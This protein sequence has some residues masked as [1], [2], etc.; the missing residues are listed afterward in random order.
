[1]VSCL[2]LYDIGWSFLMFIKFLNE[3][4]VFIGKEIFL[5]LYFDFFIWRF[6]FVKFF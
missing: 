4:R 5:S 1:M 2:F 6:V 3:Y